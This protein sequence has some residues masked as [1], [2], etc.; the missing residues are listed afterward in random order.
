MDQYVISDRKVT[1]VAPTLTVL[2]DATKVWPADGML[3]VEVI[4]DDLAQS[5]D[6]VLEKSQKSTGPWHQSP[7]DAFR[8]IAAGEARMESIDVRGLTYVRLTGTASGAG[9]NARVSAIL[10]SNP[11]RAQ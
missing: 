4:N 6:V 10:Y 9:L 2:M 11:E 7:Y 3:S 1:A 5:L 8:G